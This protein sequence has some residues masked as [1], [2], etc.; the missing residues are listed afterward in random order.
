VELDLTG[1]S[2]TFGSVS[3]V[4]FGC[5]RPGAAS[6][7]EL[8]GTIR[9]A[10]LNGR[11][12]PPVLA[13]GRLA[14]PDL[15]ADNELVV[16]ADGEY[17][18]TGEGLHRFVDPVDG[19]V[20]LYAM[21][22]LN[23]AQRIFCCFDQPD[24]KAPLTLTVT[25]PPDWTVLANERGAASTPGHW[26][27][28]TTQPIA[29]SMTTLC[30]GPYHSR[31]RDGD[32]RL[33]WH[34]RRSLAGYLDAQADELFDITARCF[35]RYHEMFG[36]RY[37][38]GDT[39]DQVLVPEFN[40][41]AMENPGC[42]TFRD[43]LLFR[44]AVTDAELQWRAAVI[45]HE[46][47]HMWFG[48]LVTLRWWDDLWLNE[49]FAEYLGF[50][51]T[52]EATRFGHAWAGFTGGRKLAGYEADQS[53][54]THPVAP[55]E[56]PDA[57]SALVNFDAISY[58]KGASAL[59]Q[60]AAWLGD[61]AFLAGLRAHFDRHR[62]GNATL[63]DL[64]DALSAASGQDVAG[65]AASWLRTAGVNR[66]VPEV[67]VT[68]GR[69]TTVH[70]RQSG[71]D[72]APDRQH[73]IGIGLY[74]WDGGELRAH[75]RTRVTVRG[76]RTAVPE[77]VGSAAADLML[78]NDGDLTFATVRL[79]DGQLSRLAELLPAVADPQ[80]RA[81]LWATAWDATRTGELAASSFVDL[82]AAAV[83]AETQIPLASSMLDRARRRVADQY[84]PPA[85]RDR[86]LAALATACA[87]LLAAAPAGSGQALVAFRTLISC[88][89]DAG[90]LA[91]WLDDRDLPP[92]LRLDAELRWLIV[93]RRAVLGAADE[94]EIAAE[95][96]RDTTA[97]GALHALWCRAARPDPAVKAAT[98]QSL[99]TDAGLSNRQIE[100]LGLGFWQPEQADLTAAYVT[101]FAT[102]ILPAAALRSREMATLLTRVAF[103]RYAI[104]QSTVDSVD[105]LLA[106]DL[107]AGVR[108]ALVSARDETRVA[109]R[110]RAARNES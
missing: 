74:R 94:T 76:A 9:S 19:A 106:G 83:G 1:T 60:L 80:A 10:T 59:R 93:R 41:G 30:A 40:A 51:V 86:A 34:C 46:M 110:G 65:W 77:L 5:T 57:D 14:L 67:S 89:T 98:W 39:Y 103:P 22:F 50:R 108:R 72:G 99:M 71:V 11:P 97:Q 68:D 4:R 100:M 48:D 29:T 95:A 27:F 20:H 70:V 44:A 33:G 81:L 53:S 69:Y 75:R 36:V 105:A 54:W 21:S 26:T 12:L 45:A 43:E 91:G 42:V 31:Y 47:A 107:D 82:V 84:L 52:G 102:G 58:P 6:F 73:R 28:A 37:A 32:I 104:E 90:Q 7:A 8:R 13:D 78:L 79:P 49:S 87:D 64:V 3:R 2:G 55:T 38:F 17:S 18:N 15:A 62:Y 66:L 63:A 85:G 56:V 61:D 92:G 16:A 101:R 35:A 109:L 23:H 25:A 24:L 88:R 96:D